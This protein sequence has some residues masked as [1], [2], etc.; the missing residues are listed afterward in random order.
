M[1]KTLRAE[2]MCK[3]CGLMHFTKFKTMFEVADF[4]PSEI[5]QSY[6]PET[7]DYCGFEWFEFRGLEEVKTRDFWFSES[8]IENCGNC[9]EG[10]LEDE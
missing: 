9:P 10:G 7:C 2:T 4:L 8:D 1:I 3:K 5:E 6:S